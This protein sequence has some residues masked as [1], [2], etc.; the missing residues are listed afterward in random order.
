[1]KDPNKKSHTIM[2]FGKTD[3]YQKLNIL[4]SS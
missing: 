2:Y 4:L 3:Y 1:M